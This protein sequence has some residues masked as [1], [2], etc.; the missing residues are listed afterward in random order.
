MI[1]YGTN[2]I[3]WS[4][5]DDPKLG[6]H[7]PLEQCLDETA[8][9]GFDGI[10]N[11]N[12]FPR[13]PA[14]LKAVLKPRG[15]QFVSGWTS[16]DLLELSVDEQK[17]RIQGDID[18]LKAM[19]CS[20]A[21]ACETSNTVH[22]AA[23]PLSRKPVLAEDQWAEFGAKV[24]AIA[25][26]TGAQGL[27]LVYHPH[28]GTVVETPEE[29]DRFLQVTGPATR[30]LF[31]S[32]H[33]YFGGGDPVAIL[34][35]HIDRVGHF[36]AKNVRREIMDQVRSE[37]LCFLDGVRRGVFTVPGDPEGSIDF[38]PLI[39]ILARARY[40]GWI[41]I[42]AEQDPDLRNPLEYQTLGL[43]TLKNLAAD[44]GLAA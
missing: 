10:E 42:E 8:Q 40:D 9:I 14:E 32:G 12:K 11:G 16:L 7:I 37:D 34:D 29:I 23:T 5:D 6:G 22:G 33:V 27:P 36:H 21:I 41:V 30:Y 2:P 3:A 28:M 39:A 18:R 26:W 4:N 15:L 20:V 38:A 1:R 44:A 31:D 13:D 43:G 25:E 17:A 35:R 19:G 24:E